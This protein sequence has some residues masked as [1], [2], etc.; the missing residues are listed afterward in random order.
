MYKHTEGMNK[1]K[2]NQLWSPFLCQNTTKLSW[3]EL[4]K[5]EFMFVKFR[6]GVGNI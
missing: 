2:K 1:L 4:P 5:T 3:F 6:G